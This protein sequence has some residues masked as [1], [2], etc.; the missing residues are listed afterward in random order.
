MSPEGESIKPEDEDVESEDLDSDK[1]QGDETAVKKERC[2]RRW[3][4]I[5]VLK[6]ILHDLDFSSGPLR[7]MTAFLS[8]DPS[9][10]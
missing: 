7:D 3:A 10:G 6:E 5:D 9:G 2:G 1:T 8:E 4:R